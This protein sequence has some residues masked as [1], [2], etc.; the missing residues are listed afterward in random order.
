MARRSEEMSET[1]K[2]VWWDVFTVDNGRRLKIGRVNPVRPRGVQPF[3]NDAFEDDAE[4][5]RYVEKLAA[6]GNEEARAALM[7]VAVSEGEVERDG[8]DPVVDEA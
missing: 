8:E 2:G 4:A 1:L 5:L 7:M 3:E 6:D